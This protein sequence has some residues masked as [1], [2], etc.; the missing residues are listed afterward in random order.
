MTEK[1]VAKEKTDIWDRL[2]VAFFI[3][4]AFILL[5]LVGLFG[6]VVIE[7]VQWITSK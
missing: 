2:G 3:F 6:W 5:C 1:K 7:I 4:C